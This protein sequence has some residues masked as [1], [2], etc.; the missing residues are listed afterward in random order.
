[1][2]IKDNYLLYFTLFYIIGSV[3]GACPPMLKDHIPLFTKYDPTKTYTGVSSEN[4]LPGG[5]SLFFNKEATPSLPPVQETTTNKTVQE[6]T[7]NETVQETTTN[8]N[9]DKEEKISIQ[10]VFDKFVSVKIS[11][12]LI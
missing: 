7:T 3:Y 10:E 11:T 2:E 12:Y 4:V 1:M 8:K 6:T 9:A 5:R